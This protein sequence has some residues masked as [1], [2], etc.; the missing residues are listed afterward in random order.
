MSEETLEQRVINA[1][2]QIKPS[3]QNDGGDIE[4][5]KMEGNTV[6]VKLL[7]ACA[8]CPMSQMTLKNGV[9]RYLQHTV[10]PEIIVENS[11]EMPM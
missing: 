6:Y 3:L 2:N 9:Q 10:G 5:I 4:F 1:L 7:G 11:I 8:G